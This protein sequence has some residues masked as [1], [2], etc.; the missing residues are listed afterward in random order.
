VFKVAGG[1]SCVL[2]LC[3]LVWLTCL[4]G[5][6]V[7]GGVQRYEAGQLVPIHTTWS[8]AIATLWLQLTVSVVVLVGGC[9][10]LSLGTPPRPGATPPPTPQGR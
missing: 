1:L 8:E 10:L 9:F 6:L 3:S 5:A 7:A 2:G 4:T